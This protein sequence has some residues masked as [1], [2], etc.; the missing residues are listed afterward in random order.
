MSR[1]T[2]KRAERVADHLR[3]EVA[4]I[5]ARKTKDP[6]L[7]LV[8]VTDVEL[9]NDLRSARVY[10]ACLPGGAQ[11]QEV[12]QGLRS[13]VGFIRTELGRRLDLRYIP[14]LT[15]LRDTSGM[16]GERMEKLLDQL[17]PA[18]EGPDEIP[19]EGSEKR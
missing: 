11:E 1:P 12:F 5:L 2:Y 10:V 18:S 4:D 3:M 6:R 17:P 8:T 15:F 16:Y 13:A 19:G 14:A 7:G 9:S